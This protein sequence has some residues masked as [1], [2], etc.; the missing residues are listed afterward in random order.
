MFKMVF[1]KYIFLNILNK[2]YLPLE[3]ESPRRA[4]TRLSVSVRCDV[5]GNGSSNTREL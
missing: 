1:Y 4:F 2:E 3:D 5:T